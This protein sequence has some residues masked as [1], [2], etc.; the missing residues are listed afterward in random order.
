MDAQ[1]KYVSTVAGVGGS[2]GSNDGTGTAAR[3][4]Q[5]IGIVVDGTGNIYVTEFTNH[6]IRRIDAQSKYVST[7]AGVAGISG[8]NDGTGTAARF[9]EPIAVAVDGSGNIYVVEYGNHIIRRIDAQSKYVSTLAGAGSSNPGSADGTG[10]AAKFDDP[11]GV[12]LDAA[13]N[14]Y[15]SDKDSNII[16]WI[17]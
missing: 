13:G 6:T 15:V 9:N 2:A 1:T 17:R 11:C 16:R 12:A 4:N 5:P 10:T 3:L 7:V 8:A 14:I